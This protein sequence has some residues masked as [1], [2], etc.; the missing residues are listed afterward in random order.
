MSLREQ[1]F[2]LLVFVYPDRVL[3]KWINQAEAPELIEAGWVD[4]T[5]MSDSE[6]DSL[7]GAKA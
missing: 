5:D 3:T 7:I 2:R 1:G 6:Y 4:A